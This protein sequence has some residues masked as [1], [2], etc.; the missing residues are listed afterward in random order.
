VS[1]P[2]RAPP[3]IVNR[4]NLPPWA[5]G[6]HEFQDNPRPIE[7]AGVRT[8]D[9]RLFQ[10]LDTL[11]EATERSRTFH[12][13]LSVKFRLHEWAEHQA[14]ARS[15]LRASYIQYL[16]GWG[17]DSNGR[18]GAVLKAWVESRFGLPPTYHGGRLPG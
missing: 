8:A 12:E 4:C 9:R 14:A 2:F 16:H 3:T 11:D 13:Y 17:A 18:A 5:I 1:P 10:R 7:V 6:G 15:A